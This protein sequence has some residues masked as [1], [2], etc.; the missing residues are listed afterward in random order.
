MP[1]L[2]EEDLET[3]SKLKAEA[4]I[5]LVSPLNRHPMQV[6]CPNTNHTEQSLKQDKQDL[7]K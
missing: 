2:S 6:R 3:L 5:N 4:A 7:K 1:V